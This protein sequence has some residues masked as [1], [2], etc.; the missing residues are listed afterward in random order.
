V[1][2]ILTGGGTEEAVF[3]TPDAYRL[4]LKH[5][6]Y[7]AG[8][9]GSRPV[10]LERFSV[11]GPMAAHAVLDREGARGW[12]TLPVWLRSEAVA[13]LRRFLSNE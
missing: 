12:E 9:G 8:Y 4:L 10:E 6:G 11:T 3:G 1:P 5:R 7:G 13:L 2:D